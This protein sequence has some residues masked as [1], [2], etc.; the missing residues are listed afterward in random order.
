MA[1]KKNIRAKG[2]I[3]LSRYFQKFVDGDSVTVV[4]E[5]SIPSNFPVR[6]QGRTGVIENKRGRNYM[7]KIKDQAKEKQFLIAPVHLKKITN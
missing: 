1:N 4:K 5:M 6:L 2:K 3:P 7:V